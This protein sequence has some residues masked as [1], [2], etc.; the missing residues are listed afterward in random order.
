M[1]SMNPVVGIDCGK[2]YLDAALFPGT[3]RTRLRCA[4]P[5][6]NSW[7]AWSGHVGWWSPSKPISPRG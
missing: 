7:L 2:R 3:D 5:L 1:I 4:I 6:A